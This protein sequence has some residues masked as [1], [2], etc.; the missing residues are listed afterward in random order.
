MISVRAA[1]PDI[2]REQTP[3]GVPAPRPFRR[4]QPSA[5]GDEALLT[6]SS[7]ATSYGRSSSVRN[8]SRSV[9]WAGVRAPASGT[10]TVGW[11][12]SQASATA[13]KVVR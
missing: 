11:A 13:G 2:L 1:R 4:V 5:V 7:W 3:N 9:S 8:G 6:S 10:A 12:A